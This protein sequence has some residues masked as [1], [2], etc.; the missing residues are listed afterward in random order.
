VTYGATDASGNKAVQVTRTVTVRD[1]T[2]PVCTLASAMPNPVAINTPFTLTMQVCDNYLV[3]GGEYS[4]N[5]G[6]SWSPMAALPAPGS[7]VTLSLTMQG[8]VATS[9]VYTVWLR[10]ADPNGNQGMAEPFYLVVYDPAGGFVTGGGWFTSP[11]GAYVPE[12][13]AT[14]KAHFGFVSKYVKGK[15]LP[16][17][18]TEFQFQAVGLNFHSESYEW[19]VV[20]GAK[21][22]F[23]GTGAIN[24]QGSYKFILTAG[25]GGLKAAGAPDTVRIRIW[26]EN[27]AGAIE[28]VIYDNQLGNSE[29]ADATTALGGG[30]IVIQKTK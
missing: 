16:V 12:P 6:Q 5:G 21:A 15:T 19:L 24:G 20:A 7:L 13:A 10:A 18:T 4:L 26:K 3:A 1:T 8:G 25:D 9:G 14:G 11:T 27:S 28:Q 22:M 30:S 29:D 23:K 2:Q 17:G